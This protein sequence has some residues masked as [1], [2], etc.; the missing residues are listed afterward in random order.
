MFLSRLSLVHL[1]LSPYPGLIDTFFS[2]FFA[3]KFL[4][5][6]LFFFILA[7][8]SCQPTPNGHQTA[9]PMNGDMV[10]RLV[11]LVKSFKLEECVARVI[12]D[13]SCK[14]ESFGREGRRL[15]KTMV[16]IQTSGK[17]DKDDMKYFFN[18]GVFGRK[19]KA[20]ANCAKCNDEFTCP[21][22]TSELVAVSPI[23]KL[24]N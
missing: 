10:S 16:T 24:D 11:K 15:L 22:E 20:A 17:V 9:S 14:P 3:M 8:A 23:L 2:T 18:A 5:V 12:C 4:A 13:L 7:S 1:H 21:T 6:C 19:A